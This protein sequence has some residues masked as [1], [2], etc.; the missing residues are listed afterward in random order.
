MP[1]GDVDRKLLQRTLL[2]YYRILQANRPLP[3]SLAWP[4]SPLFRL[5]WDA[6]PDMGVRFL[7]IRCYALQTGM[8]EADRIEMERKAIGDIASVDCPIEFGMTLDGIVI[9]VDGWIMPS[10][11]I[12]RV[13]DARAAHLEPHDYYT[14]DGDDSQQPIHPEELR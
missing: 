7:A 1:V 11:E 9:E 2:A 12:K 6:H 8:M 14:P 10:M 4:L 3:S 13:A 5:I